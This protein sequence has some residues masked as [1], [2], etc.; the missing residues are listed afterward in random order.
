MNTKKVGYAPLAMPNA[1]LVLVVAVMNV[2][3]VVE[4]IH[5]GMD[6]VSAAAQQGMSIVAQFV[7]HAH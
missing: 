4:V 7:R 2:S 1:Q 5:S 3:L 6:S